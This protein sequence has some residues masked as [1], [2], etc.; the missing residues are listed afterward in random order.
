MLYVSRCDSD[1]RFDLHVLEFADAIT[2]FIGNPRLIILDC[3]CSNLGIS[4]QSLNVCKQ[5]SF[6]SGHL[7]FFVIA[8]AAVDRIAF[9]V[10][11]QNIAYR[12]L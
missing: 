3:L 10:F 7:G 12:I 5:L 9:V 4:L 1:T 8:E 2:N 11:V 6:L